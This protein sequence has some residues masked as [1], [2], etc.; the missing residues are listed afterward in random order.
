MNRVPVTLC[1]REVADP[2]A[3]TARILE[4]YCCPTCKCAMQWT[5]TEGR[6]TS[7]STSARVRGGVLDFMSDV[8]SDVESILDWPDDFLERVRPWLLAV[9]DG[10]PMDMAQHSGTRLAYLFTPEGR[11][12]KLGTR[13]AYHFYERQRERVEEPFKESLMD[14]MKLSPASRLMNVG[15]GAGQTLVHVLDRR[16]AEA[17]G[18]D[19]DLAAVALGSRRWSR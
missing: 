1:E 13:I 14:R 16:T 4:R 18:S 8:E 15:C 9:W 12:T 2:R 7:C 5:S 11:L 10:R 3:P 6:C 17:T 19:A